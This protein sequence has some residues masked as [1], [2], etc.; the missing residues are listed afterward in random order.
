MGANFELVDKKTDSTYQEKLFSYFDRDEPEQDPERQ[1]EWDSRKAA[2]QEYRKGNRRKPWLQ[3]RRLTYDS[4][5]D[6]LQIAGMNGKDFYTYV[7]L[8]AEWPS[9]DMRTI[10]RCCDSLGDETLERVRESAFA[11]AA[12]WWRDQN[13][14]GAQP[15]IRARAAFFRLFSYAE[16]SKVPDCLQMAV[17]DGTASTNISLAD[18]PSAAKFLGINLHWLLGFPPNL[19]FFGKKAMTDEVLDAYSFMP[20]ASQRCFLKALETMDEGDTND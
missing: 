9:P 16:R 17:K 4:L 5:A 10:A 1:R 14:L 12:D 18:F 2:F 13:L 6:I 11:L 20:E 15:T 7:G 3:E 8:A 19:A